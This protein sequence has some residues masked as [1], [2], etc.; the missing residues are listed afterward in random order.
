MRRFAVVSAVVLMLSACGQDAPEPVGQRWK[1]TG[2][3]EQPQTNRA[4]LSP[5][6]DTLLYGGENGLCLKDVDGSNE[7]CVD[8]DPDDPTDNLDSGHAAWSPDGSRLAIT[9]DYVFGVE[10]DISVV[11]VAT[12]RLT[13]LTDDGVVHDGNDLSGDRNFPDGAL[14]DFYPSWTADGERIRFLRKDS[15]GVAVMAVP[16]DGGA[17]ARIGTLD[18]D[19]DKLWAAAWAEDSIAFMSR[20]SPADHGEVLV[21]AISG[22]EQHKVLDGDYWLLSFSADGAFL[23]ADEIQRDGEA[24][25][26]KARVVP[27]RGGDPVPVASGKVRFPT[28]APE[29]H[30]IA[31]VEEP[32]TIKVI[33]KP[34]A[35]PQTLHKDSE[36]MA[37][38]HQ[39]LDWAPGPCSSGP[40]MAYVSDQWFVTSPTFGG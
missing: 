7:R 22:D 24:T 13:R 40:D 9:E 33:A 19:W 21:S 4:N 16:A 37:A 35:E 20:A 8:T 11:D 31:Y 30:A 10:P 28:W 29:G 18:T 38:D 15:A 2:Q 26:G 36:L 14:V 1:V 12:G 6:G 17:P 5:D 3:Q 34:G 25:S 23:L 39:S 27:V 32:G